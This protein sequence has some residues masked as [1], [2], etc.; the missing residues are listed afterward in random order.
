MSLCVFTVEEHAAQHKLLPGLTGER[1]LEGG[2]GGEDQFL[3][4]P[5]LSVQQ[6]SAL[7]LCHVLVFILFPLPAVSLLY[8]QHFGFNSSILSLFLIKIMMQVY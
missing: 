1:R 5:L 7:K 2:E 8:V 3:F 6:C 4:S